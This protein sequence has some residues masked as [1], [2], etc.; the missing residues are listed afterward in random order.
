MLAS[1]FHTTI[2][3][4]DVLFGILAVLVAWLLTKLIVEVPWFAILTLFAV[5]LFGLALT[6]R[7]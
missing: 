5:V 2:D 3:G 6:V 7:W 1:A 4:W